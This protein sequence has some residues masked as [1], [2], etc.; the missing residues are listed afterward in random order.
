MTP[1]HRDPYCNNPWSTPGCVSVLG[2]PK[3]PRPQ[4]TETPNHQDLH[5]NNPWS[6]PGCM[7]MLGDSKSPRPQ[8]TETPT[9]I[10][11][12]ARLAA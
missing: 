5:C 8:I 12:G 6:M 10:T 2:D 9:A 4:I 1:N 11:L 7:S 3:S